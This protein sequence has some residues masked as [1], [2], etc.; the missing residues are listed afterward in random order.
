[1]RQVWLERATDANARSIG[2]TDGREALYREQHLLQATSRSF[3]ASLPV[4]AAG[5]R[6][7]RDRVSARVTRGSVTV[8]FL[9]H[10]S[11]SRKKAAQE[12]LARQLAAIQRRELFNSGAR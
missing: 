3:R 8:T 6:Q 4:A 5:R 1:M 10:R 11:D 12:E 2:G 9:A 7:R